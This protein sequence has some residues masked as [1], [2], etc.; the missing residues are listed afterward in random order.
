MGLHDPSARPR[1]PVPGGVRLALAAGAA[2]V[3]VLGGWGLIRGREAALLRGNPDAPVTD[4]GLQTAALRQGR[5]VFAR[6]C[7]TCHGPEGRGNSAGVPDLTDN[8]WLYGSGAVSE[9]EQ[10]VAYGI[11]SGHPKGWN[12]AIMPAYGTPHPSATAKI[13]PLSP[14][15]IRDVIAFLAFRRDA[16]PRDPSSVTR[17][18]AIYAGR[19]GCFDCH[20]GDAR[21][22]SAIG[23]PNLI[24][25]VWLYGADDE[26][27]ASI[28]E[29]RRGVM[30]AFE[31][32]L[33]PVN[34]RE[35]ALYVHSLSRSTPLSPE[36]R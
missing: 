16:L 22:D 3:L 9:I 11:R 18:Q 15:D 8:D 33:S 6:R 23:A 5:A 14:G 29:G 32:T 20:G 4:R 34:L 10:T 19:G 26:V 35:V 21:G 1:G 13:D 31:K 2:A 28:A 24:D 27:F 36:A 30:P 17:G 7:A 12:L 25:R